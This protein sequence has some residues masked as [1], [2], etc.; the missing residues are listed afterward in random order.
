M[1][2]PRKFRQLSVIQSQG[3]EH[4]MYEDLRFLFP[5]GKIFLPRQKNA[6]NLLYIQ[7]EDEG[8]LTFR[9]VENL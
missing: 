1:H 2:F 9:H 8:H 5:G 3:H 4:G 7:V 6:S